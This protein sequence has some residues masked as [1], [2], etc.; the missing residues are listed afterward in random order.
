MLLLLEPVW[1][2]LARVN[3]WDHEMFSQGVCSSL[4]MAKDSPELK[5]FNQSCRWWMWEEDAIRLGEIFESVHRTMQ[6]TKSELILQAT[7][8][9]RSIHLSRQSLNCLWAEAAIIRFVIV[10][11]MSLRNLKESQLN[12]ARWQS[13]SHLIMANNKWKWVKTF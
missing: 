1:L 2:K 3:K 11:K 12:L 10:T 6:A 8:G 9:I 4:I 7:Q 5:R 13:P